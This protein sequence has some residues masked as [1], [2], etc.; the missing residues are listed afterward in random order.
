M[1]PSRTRAPILLLSTPTL[2]PLGADTW[3]HALIARGLD[4]DAFE[5]HVACNPGPAGSPTP[6][7]QA[8]S[9]IPDVR[10]RTVNLGPELFGKR[11]L[12]RV[13][14]LLA[15]A[16]A[17]ASL[18]SLARYVRRNRI[19]ILHTTDRP[20]D[21]LA[22]VLL[23]RLTGARSLVHVHVAFGDW[24]SPA[25]RWSFAHADALVGVSGYVA[26]T[27]V[28]AGYPPQRT[29]AVLN[30]IDASAW[31]PRL[32]PERTRA[33]LGIPAGAPVITCV[34][35]MFPSKGQAELVRAFAEVRQKF[36]DARLL[37]VGIDVT[38]AHAF[39]RE[40]EG[41]VEAAGLTGSVI[42]SG[43]RADVP[44]IMGATDV[45][46]MASCGE[47]FGLVYAEAMAML[48][49]VV[50]LDSGGASEVVEHGKSGLL[51]APGDAAGLAKNL[52]TLLADPDLR[53]RMGQYG[54]RQVEL[55]FS[56]ARLARDVERIYAGLLGGGPASRE[57]P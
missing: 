25:L 21:A 46:A 29:H 23:A 54:R 36:P 47:P 32:D 41:L 45:F 11:G 39:T 37:L 14:G 9:A 8:F 7:F 42:F 3:I 55:R 34:A 38:P 28:D 52:V 53:R 26:R 43:H 12:A 49:P 20:R 31:D 56:P 1:A 33:S 15:T 30:A 22:T 27:L 24:M 57:A 44:Q 13:R 40:L 2:P 48:R 5:V 19:R 17:V 50:A 16:P 6:A 18:A 4:R 51:S 35:R 10:L